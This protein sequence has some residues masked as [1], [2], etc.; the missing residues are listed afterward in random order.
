MGLGLSV[1]LLIRKGSNTTQ[2]EKS[3]NI[4]CNKYDIMNKG[5]DM[6]RDKSSLN[7]SEIGSGTKGWQLTA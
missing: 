4:N 5:H 1:K 3:K 2:A 6:Q 7:K